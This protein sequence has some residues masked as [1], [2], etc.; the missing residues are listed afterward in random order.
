MKKRKLRKF[1]LPTL[2]LMILGVMAMGITFLSQILLESNVNN[3]EHYN[4]SMSV[5]N[6]TDDTAKKEENNEKE[7]IIAKPF[8]S[9]KVSVA[10]E[11]YNK[12]EST[13]N[14]EKALI[15]YEGTYMPNTGILYESE[16]AFDVTAVLDGTVKDIK[17]DEILGNVVT[18]EHDNKLTTIYYTLG[19][20]KVKVGD[21]VTQNQ[22][23][24]TSGTSKLETTKPNTLLF[25]TYVNGILTNPNTVLEKNISELN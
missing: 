1:V 5:F 2:Y 25:E 13:E 16:E 23:I 17:Q 21:K 7:I 11:Y 22:V 4:Y 10:K 8:S 12:E 18:L 24:A 15:Y 3:D 6:D 19:E 14:Q 20:T 9:E